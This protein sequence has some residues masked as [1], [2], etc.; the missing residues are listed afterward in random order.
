MESHCAMTQCLVIWPDNTYYHY[1]V[2]IVSW[3]QICGLLPQETVAWWHPVF[4]MNAGKINSLHRLVVSVN[5]GKHELTFDFPLNFIYQLVDRPISKVPPSRKQP[6][7]SWAWPG[8]IPKTWIS[9]SGN[10]GQLI[11][12]RGG[13]GQAGTR[14][15]S[16]VRN[17]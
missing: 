5:E 10:P 16:A 15:S 17:Y 7:L 13:S 3:F 6:D 2:N 12:P 4:S 8:H 11:C 1:N 9:A 14:N